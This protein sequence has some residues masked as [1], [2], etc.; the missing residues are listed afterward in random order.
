MNLYIDG[1]PDVG[2]CVALCSP[3]TISDYFCVCVCPQS[4]PIILRGV[5][6]G[7]ALQEEAHALLMRPVG[8]EA[9]HH[10][11]L[12]RQVPDEAGRAEHRL[13]E[14][15]EALHHKAERRL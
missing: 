1:W 5:G 13:A 4:S 7:V 11:D 9:W 3:G 15:A 10:H 12:P 8:V 2:L 14:A 6:L